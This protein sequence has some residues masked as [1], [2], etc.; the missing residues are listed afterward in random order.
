MSVNEHKSGKEKRNVFETNSK[1][2]TICIY[3]LFVII[4]G[5]ILV[6]CI[7]NWSKTQKTIANLFRTL[8]PFFIG[9]FIAY[10]LNPIV[11]KLD[12]LLGKLFNESKLRLS[13]RHTLSILLSYFIALGL[14]S[15][16]MIYIV[17]QFGAS[18]QDLTDRF[19]DMYNAAYDFL[20]GIQERYPNLDVAFIRDKINDLRSPLV[21]FGTNIVTNAFPLLFNIS[22]SIVKTLINIILAIVISAY[23][24][25]DKELLIRNAKRL[26]YAFLPKD[27][28]NYF[29][30]TASKCNAIFSGF[31]FGKLLDSLIIGMICFVLMSILKLPY[32]VLL[33]TIVGITNMI[34]YFGPF[35]G[36][37]PGVII[38]LLLDPIQAIV[39]AILIFILQQFDGLYLGPKILGESTGLKP[40]WVIFAITIG[41]AYFGVLGMFLGV[42]IVAVLAFLLNE[43]MNR[44]L[45]KKGIHM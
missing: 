34:P 6:Y 38:Y 26:V 9:F 8:S 16:I 4:T 7:L 28:A 42:P 44:K 18:F 25:I 13:L 12:N 22:M 23:I 32:A 14:V 43:F 37:V 41:D 20:N 45:K 31:I 33:S 2:F 35:I 5:S 1:Y 24:L 11:K 21:D 3:S 30:S 29:C 15:I 40:I 39:F 10:I 27:T 17:P 19:P 36:A